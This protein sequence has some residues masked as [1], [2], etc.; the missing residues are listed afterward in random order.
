M[1]A[2]VMT[3]S[4]ATPRYDH[5]PV[6]ADEVMAAFDLRRPARIVDG[7]LGLGGHT[8]YLLDKFAQL[9]VLGLEWDAE[10][11]AI[12]R[13]RLARFGSRVE[14]VEASYAELWQILEERGEGPVDGLLLDLGLS[15]KQ[16]MDSA[17]GFSFLKPGPLDMRMSR[18]L[19]R[20]AW[21]YVNHLDEEELSDVF[22][23]FGEEPS[24]RR[25]AKALKDALKR[26]SLMNDAWQVANTL[27]AALPGAPRRIDPATRCF[28][29]LRILVNGELD[30]VE[31]ALESLPKVIASGGR[32]AI[33]SFHSLE[34]RLVKHAF[35]AAVKGCIC[36][37]QIPQCIC[38][39]AP[40]GRL[41]FRKPLE[42]Q[43]EE[44]N[45]NPR[46]RSAKLRVMEI[47]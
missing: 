38:G 23:K 10:A 24:A 33:I 16:L 32:A 41:V 14:T 15:S 35:Q 46:S 4:F 37:G 8:E 17:R 45:A 2:L 42:A 27:R 7:T 9:Q 18:S 1:T 40:W 44:V 36:P 13:K 31:R 21:D 25:A 26:G 12:A 43:P 30:N 5:I 39:K 28:Q 11:L 6:L 29:A 3:D 19:S 34:D 47:L 22:R 20:S